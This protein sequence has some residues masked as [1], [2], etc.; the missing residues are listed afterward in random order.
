MQWRPT[1][2]CWSSPIRFPEVTASIKR[3]NLMLEI[4]QSYG[5]LVVGKWDGTKVDW[6][7]VDGVP[8]TPKVDSKKDSKAAQPAPQTPR[9]AANRRSPGTCRRGESDCCES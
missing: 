6:D 7:S 2:R 5:D 1:G 4:K 9:R 8:D 3:G